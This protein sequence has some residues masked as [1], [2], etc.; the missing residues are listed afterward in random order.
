MFG[1]ANNMRNTTEIKAIRN[2][3]QVQNITRALNMHIYDKHKLDF[4][5]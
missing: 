4:F 5:P 3:M 2:F 1:H